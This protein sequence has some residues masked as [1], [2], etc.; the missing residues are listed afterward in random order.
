M[1][2]RRSY[3]AFLFAVASLACLLAEGVFEKALCADFTLETIQKAYGTIKDIKGDFVQKST[4]KD[5]KRT[6]T[7]KGSL[8]IKVPLKMRWQYHGDNKQDTEVIINSDEIVIYQ[9][10]DKQAFRGKFDRDSYGQAPIALLAGFGK[11]GEEFDVSPEEGKLL[12]KPKRSMG[13]VVSIEVTPSGGDFPIRSLTIIDKRSNRIDIT[14]KDI[15]I[16][17]GV[18]DAAFGFSLPKDVSVF[19]YSKPQ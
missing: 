15:V 13:A 8:L 3:P 2:T 1:M 7:F 14:F 12:L 6:D 19:E 16:N 10:S 4:I 18:K 9:K 11:I 17:S 5:L